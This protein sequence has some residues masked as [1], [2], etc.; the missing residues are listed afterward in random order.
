M[1]RIAYLTT[2]SLTRDAEAKARRRDDPKTFEGDMRMPHIWVVDVATKRADKVTT[3]AFSVA[4]TPAGWLRYPG[5][6]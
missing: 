1:A 3:G 4:G 5:C 6:E 2:D